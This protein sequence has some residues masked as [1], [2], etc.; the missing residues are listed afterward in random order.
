MT[1]MMNN[2][3]GPLKD[4]LNHNGYYYDACGD[5]PWCDCNDCRYNSSY[6]MSGDGSLKGVVIGV[7]LIIFGI[8]VAVVR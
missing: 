3:H 5:R 7:A 8:I 6:N 2:D 1:N 4:G